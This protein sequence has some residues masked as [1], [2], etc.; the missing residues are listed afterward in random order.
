M[1]NKNEVKLTKN[2]IRKSWLTY[3]MGAEL[4]NSYERL[5]SLIFC[6][7]MVPILKKL[8]SKK[9]DLSEALKRHLNFFNTEGVM[10]SIIQGMVIAM[11]EERSKGEDIEENTI[12]SIK[13]GLM[14][15]MAGM[16]DSIIWGA[17]MP[18]IISIFIPFASSGSAMGGIMPLIL[19]TGI[20]VAI[21]YMFCF[22][23]YTVGKK[24]IITLLQDG[25]MKQVI[26]SANI[27][28]LI[29]M[30]A[31]SAS[32][33]TI[34]TPFKITV[35]KGSSIVVQDILNKM[36]PGILPL[37]AVFGIYYYLTKKGPRY[38]TILLAIVIIS[39]VSSLL[40]IL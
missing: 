6:A 34:K 28:G 23:G 7:S 8:Y 19:Y 10:G 36:A 1:E 17:I 27:L 9:E 26:N 33:V 20:T 18:L 2:D 31:L 32:Y 37:V 16:G 24:S 30:G 12:T 4:S 5:Q 35:L 39:V 40:G 3:Y 38:T 13:T 11:E 21:S 25:K 15:P 29:M 14:G 22:K